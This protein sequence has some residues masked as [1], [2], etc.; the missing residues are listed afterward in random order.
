MIK[1]YNIFVFLKY[2]FGLK[3]GQLFPYIIIDIK[4]THTHTHAGLEQSNKVK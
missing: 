2:N 3:D 1:Y 4:H